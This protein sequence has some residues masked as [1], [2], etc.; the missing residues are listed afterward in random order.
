M[1]NKKSDEKA[2][3]GQ[4]TLELTPDA[5]AFMDAMLLRRRMKKKDLTALVIEAL[6]RMPESVQDVLLGNVPADMRPAYLDR[7]V[8]YFT[9][10][11][12]KPAGP[13]ERQCVR[14]EGQ[15]G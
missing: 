4:V 6:A 2:R 1:R 7:T 9:G 14:H 15:V 10:L 3:R 12:N 11:L 8:A 13:E 5:E